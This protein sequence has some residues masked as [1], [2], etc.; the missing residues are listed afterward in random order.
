MMFSI[1]EER[2]PSLFTDNFC[3]KKFEAKKVMER[4]FSDEK[5]RRGNLFVYLYARKE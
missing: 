3:S 5:Q 2:V 1:Q 4:C